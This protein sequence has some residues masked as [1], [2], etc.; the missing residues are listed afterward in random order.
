MIQMETNGTRHVRRVEHKVVVVVT[1]GPNNGCRGTDDGAM[2]RTLDP[3]A[4]DWNYFQDGIIGAFKAML[5]EMHKKQVHVALLPTISGGIY[6][7]DH[8]S[9]CTQPQ[10]QHWIQ[11]ALTELQIELGG[12]IHCTRIVLVW[13]K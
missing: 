9:K 7:G 4:T 13:K 1:G 10:Y 5:R 8:K 12:P 11:Q 3:N 6:A 2:A